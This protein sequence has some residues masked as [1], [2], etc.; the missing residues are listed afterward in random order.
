[1]FKTLAIMENKKHFNIPKVPCTTEV[2]PQAVF[3]DK[4]VF[5]SGTTGF[6]PYTGQLSE[7]FEEQARQAFLNIKTILDEMGR[8]I[9][10][11]VKTSKIIISF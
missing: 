1:M 11:I 5:L 9:D 6:N 8:N 4:L 3:A 2:F 7:S 10:K